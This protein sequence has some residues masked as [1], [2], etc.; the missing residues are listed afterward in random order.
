[1]ASRTGAAPGPRWAHL[2]SELLAPWVLAALMPVLVSALTTVPRWRGVLL[3][4][5]VTVLC[6]AVPYAVVAAGVRRGRYES[7]HVRRREDRPALLAMVAGFTLLTAVLLLLL[8][9]SAGALVFLGLMTACVVVG[10]AVSRFW[11]IS[12]H[13]LVVAA[14]AVSLTGL[15]PQAWP[16]LLTVPLVCAARVRLSAHTLAQVLAGAGAGTVLALLALVL[17]PR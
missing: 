11:K 17:A 14:S 6:A 4:L 3:G 15:V 2:V 13:A 5:L 12:L 16:V 7:H 1:M 9:A 8:D 10:F